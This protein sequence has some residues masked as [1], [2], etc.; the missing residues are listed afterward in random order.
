M[1]TGARWPG[2]LLA[3]SMSNKQKLLVCV[4]LLMLGVFLCWS[5]ASEVALL[6]SASSA[7]SSTLAKAFVNAVVDVL[8]RVLSPLGLLIGIPAFVI[9]FRFLKAPAESK[10]S[11]DARLDENSSRQD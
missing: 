3:R 10:P 6:T 9:L 7:D 5:W 4:V 2:S 8:N 1:A 11:P